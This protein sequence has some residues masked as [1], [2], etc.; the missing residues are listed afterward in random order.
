MGKQQRKQK[1]KQWVWLVPVSVVVILA[2]AFLIY[3]GQYYHAGAAAHSMLQ[4]DETVSVTQTDYG[5]FFDGPSET[6]ALIFYPG[7]KVETCAYAPLL[8]GLAEKGMD[9]CLVK[10]PFRLAFFGINKANRVM[11]VHD[12]EHWYIGGHSLG[13]AMAAYYAAGHAAQL[14]GVIL[15]AAYPTKPLADNLR[16]ITIYGSEDGV[17]NRKK[18]AE[19]AKYMPENHMEFVIQGGNHAQF[20]DYGEQKGDEK[21]AISA[22]EQQHQA[23]ELI[24]KNSLRG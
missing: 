20:G 4:S 15:L 11:K 18:V 24:L 16:V 17:L 19:G 12:Y 5:W 6:D 10:I 21:A 2:A 1:R 13:G 9:V 22:Q 8:H 7:A 3:T 23:E 14:T